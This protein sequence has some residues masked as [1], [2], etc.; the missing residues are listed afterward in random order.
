MAWRDF[1]VKNFRW[2]LGALLMAMFVWVIIQF[3]ISKGFKPS[4]NSLGEGGVQIFPR[5]TVLVL[6]APGD[7]RIFK[8]TP[9]Q[10]DVSVRSSAGVLNTLKESDIRV[11]VNL[12]G[13]PAQPK[14]TNEVFVY[15]PARS[16][17][18]EIRVQ[19]SFVTV[20][21]AGKP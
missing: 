10:V 5:Q 17:A 11:F 8:I 2:K 7:P 9:A 14:A 1:I 4:D 3:A 16:E 19:P 15:A 18:S 20:E 21:P 12:A 13:L 6:T